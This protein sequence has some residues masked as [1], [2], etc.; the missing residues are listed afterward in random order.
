MENGPIFADSHTVMHR[1]GGVIPGLDEASY[2]VIAP[3]VSRIPVVIAVPHGGR[4]YPPDILARMRHPE[5]ASLR[6]R[7]YGRQV[8][9]SDCA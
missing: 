9:R 4:R 1:D 8:G 2:S 5:M 7:S 3:V 6:R